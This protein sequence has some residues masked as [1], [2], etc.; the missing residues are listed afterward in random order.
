M[1]PGLSSMRPPPLGEMSPRRSPSPRDY[2]DQ[3]DYRERERRDSSGDRYSVRSDRSGRYR[4]GGTGQLSP[5]LAVLTNNSTF[6][7]LLLAV[8]AATE[9]RVEIFPSYIYSI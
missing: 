6:Q 2:R 1:L 7:V 5:Q 9:Y 8:S 3:R 4:Y